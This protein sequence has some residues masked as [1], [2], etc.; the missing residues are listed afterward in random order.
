[1]KKSIFLL[2]LLFSLPLLAHDGHFPD[3]N[4]DTEN[5]TAKPDEGN[6]KEEWDVN[7]PPGDFKEIS[8]DTTTGTWMSVDVHPNGKEI[9][10]DLLG[11]IYTLPITGGEATAVTSGHAWD[12]QP[13][14]NS[15]GSRIAFTTDRDGAD[16]IWTIKTDG[17]DSKQVTKE[18]FRLLN[19]PVWTPDGN[20][21]AARK[22]FT[23]TRSAGAGEIWLYHTSGG[24]GLQ[25]T[26][27]PNDQKDL[28]EPSFSPDGRYLYY[29]QD[30]TPGKNFEYN[31]DSNTQI[32]TIKRLDRETGKTITFVKGPGG[33]IRPT[34]SPDGKKLAFIRRVRF[35]TT[36]FVK[37]L[38]SG[39]ETPVYRELDRDNQEAWAIHGVYPGIAWTPDSKNM[40]LWAGGK[41]RKVN[42]ATGT[43]SDIPFHVKQTH[44]VYDVPRFAVEMDPKKWRTHMLRW[45]QVSPRG[46]KV[47]FQALGHI[48]VK[49]L[50]N[51]KAKRLTKNNEFE[52]YPSWSASGQQIVYTTW[53]DEM[54]GSVKVS[55]LRGKTR[56][57]TTV[58]GHYIEPRFSADGKQVVYRKLEGGNLV[59]PDWSLD[60]GIYRVS[61]RKGE[62]VFV[63]DNGQ[64]PFFSADGQRIFLQ[65]H[66]KYDERQLV[67]VD[68]NGQDER[69][70]IESVFTTEYLLSPDEKWLAFREGYHVWITPFVATGKAIK[71]GPE[72][73]SIPISK[74][75]EESGDFLHFSGD[76]KTLHW[77]MGH[78]LYSQKIDHLFDFLMHG[79]GNEEHKKPSHM[80]IGFEFTPD[81]PEGITALTGGRV[82]TMNGEE[83]FENG[84]VLVKNNRILAVGNAADITVPANAKVFDVSGKTILPGIIDSH[85][86][87]SQGKGQIIPEKNYENYAT[88]ALGVTTIHDPSNN[89]HAIFAAS[90]MQKAGLIVG[91]RIFSTGRILYGATTDFTVKI[92]SLE[93]ARNHLK[94]MK[95]YGAFSVK[96]YNQPRREQRQQVLTAAH[97]L[98]IMVVP[99]GGSLFV[100]NMNMILDGHTTIEH[101][102]PVA[103]IYDDV[104]QLWSQTETASTPTLV[105]A[106]GG[107]SGE[108]YWYQESNVWEHP[109]L[110]RYVPRT[111]L[112]PRARRRITAPDNEWNHIQEAAVQNKLRQNG[113]LVTT[114][115][116]GQREG[117]GAHWE[118]WMLEQGGMTAY[119]ALRAATIDGAKALG[120]DHEVGSL[121]EGK[122]ADLFVVDGNP[123]ENLRD[124]DKVNMVMV[125]GRLY[126]SAT[127]NQLAPAFEERPAFWFE[128]C[129]WL[130]GPDLPCTE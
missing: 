30:T 129:R 59:S 1:M 11:D 35:Q 126:E 77:A 99:E 47:L 67:S 69:A 105:V 107:L 56:T 128:D 25:M 7:N 28:G 89:S 6:N 22:H 68:L 98:G 97:E 55:S 63:S 34:P 87:G 46:D 64:E 19:S 118:I 72:T 120:M 31:K 111:V 8:V 83:V 100:H 3:A 44:K 94:R 115:A 50:P 101:N 80:E 117:L 12:E 65:R 17:T 38:V 91:P 79:E 49:D 127:M 62:P 96:S 76:S 27:K 21:I 119:E 40:V 51:G 122:L 18:N 103:A 26:K 108:Y 39:A 86:H 60:P 123:L 43:A 32:Y 92:N 42:V 113:V 116:H 102:I 33:A 37:D 90:E 24:K 5:A 48:Y 121:E 23:S 14:Y 71:L 20:Y 110:S 125:N 15:D 104:V 4:G 57:L 61:T 58:P 95:A 114:G 54:L 85:W 53:D 16:N 45:V 73:K 36:L 52:F 13:R 84:V 112:D 29:S 82:V 66:K 93:D 9:V 130:G 106:Y 109:I 124:S 75:S 41:I 10:F 70:H 74:A 88:L 78:T 81:Q 2:F